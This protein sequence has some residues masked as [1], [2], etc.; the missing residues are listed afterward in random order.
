MKIAR[1]SGAPPPWWL[2]KTIH[3]GE[4]EGKVQL[5]LDA[6][7]HLQLEFVKGIDPHYRHIMTCPLCATA[8][9]FRETSNQ[10]VKAVKY[11]KI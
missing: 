4:C 10:I 7:Y 5:S 1:S 3:C 6:F 2:G 9:H 11:Y 8:I